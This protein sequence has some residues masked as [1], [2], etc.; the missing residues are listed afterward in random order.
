M[1]NSESGQLPG[2][3]QPTTDDRIG[4][5]EA[6][7]ESLTQRLNLVT[8]QLTKLAKVVRGLMAETVEESATSEPQAGNA[9]S[10]PPEQ[11][12]ETGQTPVEIPAELLQAI[13]LLTEDRSE[14]AQVIVRSLPR[15]ML[16]EFPG[17]VAMVAAAVRIRKGQFDVAR[18]A[19]DKSRELIEDPRLE[20]VI[21]FL[22]KKLG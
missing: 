11:T 1:D 18:A 16:A 7:V 22:E 2:G 17:I 12:A 21:S 20:K 14:E 6:Q 19:L 3:E 9:G 15:E 8:S 13:R 4:D 5:L 10:N